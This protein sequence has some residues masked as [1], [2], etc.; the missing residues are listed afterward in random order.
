[1]HIKITT[2]CLAILSNIIS[3]HYFITH[4]SF[5]QAVGS[6]ISLSASF[7]T[8]KIMLKKSNN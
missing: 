7:L 2:M 4:H 6:M 5:E 3:I 8:I 1:M